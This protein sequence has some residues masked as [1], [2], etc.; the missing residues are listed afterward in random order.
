M[1]QL[2]DLAREQ[3]RVILVLTD[4]DARTGRRD[5]ALVD[6]FDNDEAA[7]V[8]IP[9]ALGLDDPLI[10]QLSAQNRLQAGEL[11]VQS[12]YNPS[13][14]EFADSAVAEFAVAKFMLIS[15]VCQFLG[16]TSVT[17]DNVVARTRD[18]RILT[19]SSGG[20][21]VQ[22]GSLGTEYALG[23]SVRERLEVH[24]TFPGGPADVDGARKLL[25]Q[26]GLT[27]DATLESVI[28]MR[29]NGNRLT[30]REIK[31][32]LTQEAHHNLHVAAKYSGLKMV[33]LSSGFTRQ[34]SENVDVV[35][36]ATITFPG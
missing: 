27:G 7:V 22:S 21:V 25:A 23:T 16:A 1:R 17:V 6:Y 11:L 15:R 20:T 12:P 4:E 13:R 10:R 30:K 32:S 34:V 35:L 9:G 18:E 33:R 26:A 5:A 2:S 3:R 14:Y 29:A 24:D 28:D 19:E 8:T 31:L 36:Q